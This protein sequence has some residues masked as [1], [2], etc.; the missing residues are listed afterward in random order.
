M[1]EVGHEHRSEDY[2]LNGRAYLSLILNLMLLRV[3]L[4]WTHGPPHKHL[5]IGTNCRHT[6][7]GA[8]PSL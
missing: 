1:A 2:T 8:A 6:G 4:E 5:W 7:G 3:Q